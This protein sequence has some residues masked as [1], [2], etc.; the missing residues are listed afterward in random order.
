[1]IMKKFT[2]RTLSMVCAVSMMLGTVSAVRAE[3]E[4][5]VSYR[6]VSENFNTYMG[7]TGSSVGLN[8]AQMTYDFTN[9]KASTKGVTVQAEDEV[10]SSGIKDVDTAMKISVKGPAVNGTDKPYIVASVND[11][12]FMTSEKNPQKLSF[13]FKFQKNCSEIAM[14]AYVYTDDYTKTDGTKGNNGKWMGD[15]SIIKMSNT[16]AYIF[17]KKASV[18]L[19]ASEWYSAELYVYPDNTFEFY[20]GDSLI[21]SQSMDDTFSIRYGGSDISTAGATKF[22]GFSAVWLQYYAATMTAQ[23]AVQGYSID[24]LEVAVADPRVTEVFFEDFND[25]SGVP[26]SGTTATT[27]I[28]NKDVKVILQPQ[29]G[30][31]KAVS[32]GTN[33]YA[34]AFGSDVAGTTELKPYMQLETTN[35][36]AQL[37]A[38]GSGILQFDFMCDATTKASVAG[39]GYYSTT[40]DGESAGSVTMALMT[41]SASQANPY[42]DIYDTYAR[43]GGVKYQYG[44]ALAKNISRNKWHTAVFVMN[45]DNTFS[46]YIDGMTVAENV[47]TKFIK[48]NAEVYFRGFANVRLNQYP[49]KVSGSYPAQWIKYDNVKVSKT[50]HKYTYSDSK[51]VFCYDFDNNGIDGTNMT[52]V[53]DNR[54]KKDDGTFG[55][56]IN[57]PTNLYDNATK[58]MSISEDGTMSAQGSV[59]ARIVADNFGGNYIDKKGS[60][61]LRF[62][63]AFPQDV[64]STTMIN[65]Q[66]VVYTHGWHGNANSGKYKSANSSNVLE[67]YKSSLSVFGKSVAL[68]NFE[69]EKWHDFEMVVNGDN[70]FSV[71]IDERAVI[72]NEKIELCVRFDGSNFKDVSNTDTFAGFK[73]IMPGMYARGNKIAKNVYIDDISLS[74]TYGKKAALNEKISDNAQDELYVDAALK[75]LDIFTGN[76]ENGLALDRYGL[77]ETTITWQSSNEN[78]ITNYGVVY[79]PVNG[80][81]IKVTMT[82]T[83]KSG[84]VTG[85]KDF[86]ITVPSVKPYVIDGIKT[87]AED[88][89]IDT[90][91]VGSKTVEKVS[92]KRYTPDNSGVTVIT[93]L[94]DNTNTLKSVALNRVNMNIAQYASGDITLTDKVTLPADVSGCTMKVM[95]FDNMVNLM[96]LAD[97]KK[98]EPFVNDDVTVYMA[99]DSL[100]V[101]YSMA[102]YWPQQGWGEVLGNYITGADVDDTQ[103]AGGRSAKSFIVDGRLDYILANVKKG[104]YVIVSFGH[105]DQKHDHETG[106]VGTDNPKYDLINRFDG[107]DDNY[108]SYAKYLE[109]YVDKVREKG[110]DVILATSITR[111]SSGALS[112]NVSPAEYPAAMRDFASKKNVPIIDLSAASVTLAKSLNTAGCDYKM[113]YLVFNNGDSRFTDIPATSSY[114]NKDVSDTTHL[115]ANGAN[116]FAVIASKAI[117][118]IKHPL[119]R[120]VRDDIAQISEL[121]IAKSTAAV[122][123]VE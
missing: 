24:N 96:P 63:Y 84:N 88:N 101:D 13:D 36:P 56:S 3:A 10:G 15:T 82:A 78:V 118:D 90:A 16:T 44:T 23:D 71:F 76:V 35:I 65:M 50:A 120:F 77:Y 115:N 64:E 107:V 89:V 2:K 29:K 7:G 79:P 92:I 62:R 12:A 60:S 114:Y 51:Q 6:S 68:T 123:P 72:Q 40:A 46:L 111:I 109:I 83:V 102:K 97:M 106:D 74:S 87:S 108:N 58:Y 100:M 112:G 113:P 95:I 28:T 1:M 30:T 48:D 11:A 26:V 55:V 38:T 93:A 42:F 59:Y 4:P 27:D 25:Y 61:V 116:A 122:T 20:I 9:F 18:L 85:T 49:Q 73:E 69:T 75:A 57:E 67:L 14:A 110:A 119:S 52:K 81:D 54:F 5:L 80:D 91:L 53:I 98:V 105:N 34:L 47:K 19:E 33:D 31:V 39:Y 66:G 99:G 37:G 21:I 70:T 17:G 32:R 45:T 8:T 22:R 86:E 104:D 43:V 117:L 41:D 103:P 121:D 94:Y